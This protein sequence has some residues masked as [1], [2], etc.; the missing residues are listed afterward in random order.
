MSEQT[1][2]DALPHRKTAITCTHSCLSAENKYLGGILLNT[3]VKVYLAQNTGRTKTY[4]ANRGAR[5]FLKKLCCLYCTNSVS[6]MCSADSTA[7]TRSSGCHSAVSE[8]FA[9]TQGVAELLTATFLKKWTKGQ[10]SVQKQHKLMALPLLCSCPL[11]S[12]R[13][14]L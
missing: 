14:L 1:G 4:S 2:H 8:T 13:I 11:C 10:E 5:R 12:C 7:Q 3:L 6:S 9:L